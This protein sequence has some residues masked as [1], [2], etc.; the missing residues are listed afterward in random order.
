MLSV[1]FSLLNWPF[2]ATSYKMD[3]ASMPSTEKES[4]EEEGR[5]PS[6]CSVLA[7][8]SDLTEPGRIFYYLPLGW[9]YNQAPEKPYHQLPANQKT[10]TSKTSVKK[11]L[12]NLERDP[13]SPGTELII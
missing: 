5:G 10:F 11:E 6:R 12:S 7:P 3:S 2:I 13:K 8:D 1:M 9:K 4:G